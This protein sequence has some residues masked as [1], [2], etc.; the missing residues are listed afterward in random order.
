MSH[1]WGTAQILCLTREN[2]DSFLHEIPWESLPSTFKDAVNVTRRLGYAYLWIDSLCI[3]QDT[4]QD[5]EEESAIMGDIYR[6][7]VCTVAALDATSSREGFLGLRN[8]LKNIPCSLQFDLVQNNMVAGAAARRTSKARLGNPRAHSFA[9]DSV[10][11][12]RGNIVGMPD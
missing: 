10:F 3:L 2:Q 1:R 12:Q 4:P 11:G 9:A 5:W 6:G 7:S 8:P